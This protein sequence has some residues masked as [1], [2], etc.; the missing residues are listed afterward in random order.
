MLRAA[1]LA[2]AYL[3]GV[4]FRGVKSTR[5]KAGAGGFAK[6]AEKLIWQGPKIPRYR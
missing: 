3:K 2:R 6:F 5:A 4:V 1:V